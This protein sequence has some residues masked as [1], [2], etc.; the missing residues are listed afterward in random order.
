MSYW[1]EFISVIDL[2]SCRIL[3]ICFKSGSLGCL[4]ERV[5]AGRG[6][7][8]GSARQA[9]VRENLDDH[10]GIF[11]RRE[12]GQWPAALWTGGEVDGENAFE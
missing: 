7:W 11:D 4:H 3:Y 5:E 8:W 10:G 6:A 1:L 12:D 9:Q 2:R